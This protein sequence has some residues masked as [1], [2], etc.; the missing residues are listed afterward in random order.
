VALIAACAGGNGQLGGSGTTMAGLSCVDDSAGCIAS[1]KRTLNHLMTSTDKS[2]MATPP[3]AKAY[4]SGVRLFAYKRQ[5]D[6]LACKELRL[7]QKEARA[8]SSVLK[9]PQ[10]R[11]LSP[12]QISRGT[13]LAKEV[14]RELKRELRRRCPNKA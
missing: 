3:S 4:A 10:G 5:K 14:D 11:G 2:W 12:A 1:R 7:G 9:G 13:M 8:A 6:T